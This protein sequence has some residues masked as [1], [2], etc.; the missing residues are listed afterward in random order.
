MK[1]THRASNGK[2]QSYR[3]AFFM[4]SPLAQ[5]AAIGIP[6]ILNPQISLA[7]KMTC[8]S[9]AIHANFKKGAFP[10]VPRGTALC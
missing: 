6:G 1:Q 3:D 4:V 2:P 7:A 9:W 10:L 5:A 8:Y